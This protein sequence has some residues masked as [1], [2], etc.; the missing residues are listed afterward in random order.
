MKERPIPGTPQYFELRKQAFR[1]IDEIRKAFKKAEGSPSYTASGMNSDGEP[2]DIEENTGPW[3]RAYRVAANAVKNPFVRETLE[4][5]G[6]RVKQKNPEY[7]P[8]V[9]NKKGVR[10]GSVDIPIFGGKKK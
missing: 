1:S 7:D 9:L 5:H 3:D 10:I 2:T 8:V 4:A 6:L